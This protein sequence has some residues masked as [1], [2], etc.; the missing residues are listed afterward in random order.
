MLGAKRRTASSGDSDSDSQSFVGGVLNALFTV[1]LAFYIVF[2]WQNGDDID[3]AA[4]QEA[5]A[6]TDLH[7]QAT[8]APSAHSA[9]IQDL[10]ERYARRV[11][12]REWPA[13]DQ[14]ETDPGVD[15]LLDSLRAEVLSLPTTDETLKSTREQSLQAIRKI[16]EAH[17]ERVDVVT[18]N[19]NFNIVLLVGSTL[20][21]MLMIVFPLVIGLSMRPA[22]V[23]SMVLLTATLGFALY[24]SLELLHPLHGP[25]AVDPDA[26]HTALEGF[27]TRGAGT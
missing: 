26:F 17:Q 14:R 13:L 15:R 16:D 20:G 25:F 23:A 12:E 6:L 10:A 8:V 9:A 11:V 22:N 5:N 2:A 19:Q 7:W 1:L 24:V 21:A 3:K 4:R 18:D 27:T